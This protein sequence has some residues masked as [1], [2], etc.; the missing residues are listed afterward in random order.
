MA[1]TRKVLASKSDSGPVIEDA[2]RALALA[3]G[4]DELRTASGI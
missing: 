1:T 3:V 2:L 4:M